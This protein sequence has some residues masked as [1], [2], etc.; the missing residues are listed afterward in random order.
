[1]KNIMVYGTTSYNETVEFIFWSK[2]FI[3]NSLKKTVD[4]V[5]LMNYN[6]KY[7]KFS[8]KN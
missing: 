2:K 7:G 8:R 3:K 4:K 5:N 1:M 6:V